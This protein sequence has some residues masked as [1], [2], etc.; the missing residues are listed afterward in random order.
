MKGQ[1][2]KVPYRINQ[3]AGLSYTARRVY[4]ALCCFHLRAVHR[5]G[6]LLK[7]Y[8]EIAAM[9]GIRDEKTVA[10]AVRE[11]SDAQYIEVR[12]HGYWD[13]ERQS[14]RRGTNEYIM[15]PV[16]GSERCYVW[17]PVKLLRAAISPAAFAVLLY[18]LY[19]QGA[20]NRAYPSLRRGFQRIVQKNG[21]PMPRKTICAA[22]EQLKK[23]VILVIL[24]CV[25]RNNASSMNS[26]ILTVWGNCPEKQVEISSVGSEKRA[27]RPSLKGRGGYF[28]GGLPV[29][30]K[31]TY[32]FYE[33]EKEK[34][35]G[36]FGVLYNFL[37]G[38]LWEQ[39][40]YFD[41][42]GVK[43]FSDGEQDLTS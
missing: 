25:K 38:F 36:Q 42:S 30:T 3:D 40:F 4:C 13:E 18:L 10:K 39:S 26:Y 24:A 20:N 5:G 19:K 28:F 1:K 43:V 22:L 37:E 2:V 15:L 12:E 34:G 14:V 8:S 41:G 32:G 11:L 35:V 33:E 7:T 31:I 23:C 29:R 16:S 9:S 27:N 6:R 17:V 21:K